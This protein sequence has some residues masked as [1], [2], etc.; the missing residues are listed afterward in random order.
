M[1]CDQV[2]KFGLIS[3]AVGLP[4]SAQLRTRAC[5]AARM[6]GRSSRMACSS[7][8]FS[9][10]RSA[11]LPSTVNSATTVR[12]VMSSLRP[13]WLPVIITS[14]FLVALTVFGGAQFTAGHACDAVMNDSRL[15]LAMRPVVLSNRKTG[16]PAMATASRCF[17]ISVS[18]LGSTPVGV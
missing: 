9:I 14:V 4:A 6:R 8:R 1:T 2:A 11:G 16:W 12:R 3:S 17:R 10:T 15:P 5:S 7:R 13:T 18:L